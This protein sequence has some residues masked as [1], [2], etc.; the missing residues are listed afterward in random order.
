[1]KKT[2]IYNNL[3]KNDLKKLI[4]GFVLTSYVSIISRVISFSW[5]TIRIHF[6]QFLLIIS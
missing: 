4:T 5:A 3:F 2:R 1:M 6:F